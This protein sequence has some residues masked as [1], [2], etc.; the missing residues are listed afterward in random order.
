MLNK[1]ITGIIEE[2]YV[3][4]NF[5]LYLSKCNKKFVLDKKII[6]LFKKNKIEYEHS[7]DSVSP[8][9]M[10]FL[11]FGEFKKDSFKVKYKGELVFSKLAKAYSLSFY[12][13]I[14]NPDP[15]AYSP[16]YYDGGDD[17][18]TIKQANFLDEFL[19]ILK[20]LGYIRI[21]KKEKSM[22]IPGVKYQSPNDFYN[23]QVDLWTALTYDVL[24]KIPE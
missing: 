2:I 20:D 17:P 11:E 9:V 7:K 23:G 15:D 10:I 19:K 24:D 21:L 16:D 22:I 8:S 18:L 4:K 3:K 5:D 6:D 1:E 12:Y 13:E 14:N